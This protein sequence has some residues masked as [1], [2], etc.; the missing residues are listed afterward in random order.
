MRENFTNTLC[1]EVKNL[2]IF[3]A[4]HEWIF[5]NNS[6]HSSE[7]IPYLSPLR[8][9]KDIS[10]EYALFGSGLLFFHTKNERQKS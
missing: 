10:R 5:R 6:W 3:T 7:N 8:G 9:E 2:Y 4:S 1:C